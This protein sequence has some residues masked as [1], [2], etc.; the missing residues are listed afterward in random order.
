VT[1]ALGL[2]ALT[3]LATSQQ[4]QDMTDRSGLLRAGGAAADPRIVQMSQQGTSGL[5]G[6]WQQLQVE[7]AAQ[8]Y[9]DVFLI[10]GCCTLAGV[11]L[12]FFLR[13]GKAPADAEAVPVEM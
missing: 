6:V 1:A 12:A 10:A 2:A 7:V 4:A 5:L 3:G 9:S 11:V 8:A 13:N